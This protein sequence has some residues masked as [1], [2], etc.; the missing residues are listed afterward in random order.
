[1]V[2][3]LILCALVVLS[4][5]I[6]ALRA[7]LA[8]PDGNS[9]G[10]SMSLSVWQSTGTTT[11][12]HDASAAEPL[13]G[14]P[15]SR[16]KYDG[17]DSTIVELRAR[18]DLPEGSFVEL[19]YGAGSAYSG[20]LTDADFVSAQGAEA[21]GTAVSGAHAYSE[22]VSILDGDAVHYFDAMFGS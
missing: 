7:A 15:T 11:W 10:F 13:F 16:L 2:Q 4:G 1:M 21:F 6:C 22:T 8:S 17:V 19:A 5:P 3:R 9:P 12:S 14:N 18:A 20:H